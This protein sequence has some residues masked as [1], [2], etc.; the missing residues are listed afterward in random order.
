MTTIRS[1]TR[2]ARMLRGA[3]LVAMAGASTACAWSNKSKGTAIGTAAG[4]AAG[5]VI[6]KQAGSTAKGAILGAVVGGAA[7]AIIGNQMDRQAK[8]LEYLIPGAT[9]QRIGEGMVVTFASGLLYDFDSSAIRPEAARNLQN[10]AASLE[11]YPDTE[12]LIVGHTD[13]T[14]DSAYNERLSTRRADAA[15][16]Y[17][18]MQGV[19]TNRMRTAGKGEMEPLASNDTDEGRQLNRR[20]EV[21]IFAATATTPQTGG[22]DATPGGN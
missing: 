4:A 15:A 11:K 20:I 7:G 9:V 16:G 5:G 21:A 12:L 3:L 1:S 18:A 10:L 8:E 6:G 22:R 2:T 14:G 19:E 17:L 13:S